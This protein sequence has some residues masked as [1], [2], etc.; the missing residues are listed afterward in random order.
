MQD[1]FERKIEKTIIDYFDDVN[2]P[3]LVIEGA[4]QVGKTYIIERLGKS[5][6]EHFVS[7]N[8]I[9][10]KLGDRI[11][12]NVGSVEDLYFLIQAKCNEE[13]GDASDTLIFIDEI[14]EYPNLFTLLKFLKTDG[15]FRFIA[16][17]SLLGI[18]LRKTTSIPIGSIQMVRMYPL[19]FEEFLWAKGVS[20]S[21][22]D[23]VRIDVQQRKPIPEGIHKI[24]LRHF[25][26]YLISGGL[27]YCVNEFLSKK[28]IVSLRKIQED[29][30]ALY[31]DDASK[32]DMK[33]RLHTRSI[34]DLV[35]S[36][37]ENKKKRI[38]LKDIENK[39]YSKYSEY[40]EDFESLIGSGIVIEVKCS[41]D[42][43]FPLIQTAKNSMLKL[44]MNDVGLLSCILFRNNI[45]PLLED[46]PQVN[47]G[48][49][50]ETAAAQM[51]ASRDE[52]LFYCDSK[53]MGEVDFII[54]DYESLNTK[55]LEIKSGKDYK[56]HSALNNLMSSN[57]G[58][59]EGIV[60]SNDGRV[61]KEEAITYL[62]IYALMFV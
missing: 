56:T 17:G 25:K 32:Y 27:P 60:F 40:Q 3:I 44:Y 11:F 15:R 47:L 49:I 26:D 2:A 31:S 36:T 58:P 53:K 43:R 5:R 55:A 39:S 29:I 19:D 33:N 23:E 10:D 59:S 57:N 21:V 48:N 28:D 22:I 38:R 4:R 1:S 50:Y 34:Y 41:A 16:S 12:E 18:T 42:P 52:P 54:D 45:K 13:L 62:P 51:L 46:L 8:M 37:V 9:E 35:P 6:F 30:H 20:K 7:I 61:E 14:Q 24:F